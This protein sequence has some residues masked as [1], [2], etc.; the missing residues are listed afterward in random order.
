VSSLH[1]VAERIELVPFERAH[2]DSL[3]EWSPTSEFLL[4]WAG[5]GFTHPLD[6]SQLERLL[7]S[8]RS[9]PPGLHLYTAQPVAGGSVV[10]HAELG[11][12]RRNRSAKLMRILV[13][14]ALR[15]R[16]LGESVVRQLV[17]I[18]F[19]DLGLHRLDLNVFDFN[20]SAIR[21]YERVGFQLEGTLRDAR[22]HGDEYWNVCTMGLLRHE[23][24]PA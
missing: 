12:D 3:I 22:R 21:C 16:G 15:G 24:A 14:P 23:W 1:E 17:R 9:S 5:P 10:G 4:Q 8:A 18:G 13:S 7:E 6:H 11:V 20:H 2:F 19:E